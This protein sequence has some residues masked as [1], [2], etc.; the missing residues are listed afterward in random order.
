MVFVICCIAAVAL[1][2]AG[3]PVWAIIA[4]IVAVIIRAAGQLHEEESQSR[5]HH[6]PPPRARVPEIVEREVDVPQPYQD[7]M[8]GIDDIRSALA[9]YSNVHGLPGAG[10]NHDEAKQ[11][12]GE[13]RIKA[14]IRGE[15][16][17]AAALIYYGVLDDPHTHVFF[18]V[19]NPADATGNTDID[20]VIVNGDTVYLLDAKYWAGKGTLHQTSPHQ[21][22]ANGKTWSVTRSM[23]WALDAVR[24]L[25]LGGAQVLAAVLVTRTAQGTLGTT[26]TCTVDNNIAI[27]SA[28]GWIPQTVKPA[29]YTNFQAIEAFA[30]LVKH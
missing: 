21:Y 16:S 5:S 7:P 14:G 20:C 19:A 25:N 26:N 2:Y 3:H 23:P 22:C 6:T 29:A 30:H 12:M 8:Y 11:T 10:L 17:L 1:W 13:V 28:D 18:S 27:R 24:T 15:E 9:R 4:A